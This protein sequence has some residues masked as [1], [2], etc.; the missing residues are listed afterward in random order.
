MAGEFSILVFDRNKYIREL[1]KRELELEGYKVHVARTFHELI[2][3][4]ER[5]VVFKLMILDLEVQDIDQS[6]D[7]VRDKLRKSPEVTVVVHMFNEIPSRLADLDNVRFVE[8]NAVS[9][10]AI[11]AIARDLR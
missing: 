4:M 3:L 8:K 2:G 9:V 11:K 5:P 1:V 10:E 7:L 6:L